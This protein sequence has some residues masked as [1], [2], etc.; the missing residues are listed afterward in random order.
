MRLDSVVPSAVPC[1][2]APVRALLSPI[3]TPRPRRSEDVSDERTA[4]IALV[5]AVQD[6]EQGSGERLYDAV[7]AAV[8]RT[9]ARVLGPSAPEHDD[10]VQE[11][12]EKLVTTLMDGSFRH[13]CSLKSWTASIASHLSLNVIRTR[14]RERAVLDRRASA[15]DEDHVVGGACTERAVQ[16]KQTLAQLRNEL[17]A[18]NPERARAVVLFHVLEYDLK[19]V[20]DVLGISVAA[21]QSRVVRGRRELLQRMQGGLLE[22]DDGF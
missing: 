14:C 20:A 22:D 15:Y 10:L 1:S 16:T 13:E 6:R 11:T 4:D 17:S 9:I 18:M 8:D 5:R 2:V 19:Q 7:I 3:M 21:A 12:F